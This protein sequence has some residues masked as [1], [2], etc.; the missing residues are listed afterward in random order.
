MTIYQ[1]VLGYEQMPGNRPA[2]V[3][4]QP[5]PATHPVPV[6][7]T[8]GPWPAGDGRT[9]TTT[10]IGRNTTVDANPALEFAN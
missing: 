3:L 1:P 6:P 9:E 4:G 8:I 10:K 2:T 5:R 7:H